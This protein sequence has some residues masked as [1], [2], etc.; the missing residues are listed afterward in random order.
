MIL[1]T[2]PVTVVS[3]ERNFSKLKL[4]NTYMRS[5]MKQERLNGLVTIA[6]E[7]ECLEKIKY[8]DIIENFISKNTRRMILFNRS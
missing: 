1:L 8:E 3:A 4:L 2:I 5:T 7:I 6:L